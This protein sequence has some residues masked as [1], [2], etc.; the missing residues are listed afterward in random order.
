MAK[1]RASGGSSSG[2]RGR[3]RGR[4]RKA[5]NSSNKNK[6]PASNTDDARTAHD[7]FEAEDV[8]AD[9]DLHAYRYDDVENNEYELPEDFEDEEIDEDE[10]FNSEDE[11]LY[12]H[13][14]RDSGTSEEE[15]QEG[16]AAFDA[17]ESSS[18]DSGDDEAWPDLEQG[19]EDVTTG[20]DVYPDIGEQK[21]DGGSE[22]DDDFDDDYEKG[23]VP[24][25]ETMRERK[26]LLTEAYP[27]SVFHISTQ[28][29]NLF[30][31]F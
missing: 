6:G 31:E 11:R 16:D 4:G 25:E 13:F 27:E 26:Q 5:S 24:A 17:L 23:D 18:D 22:D 29:M 21:A 10:A 2:G 7:I 15:S 30:Y 28:G 3:G 12:G 19:G 9:E 8:D 1:R 20:E 14:F